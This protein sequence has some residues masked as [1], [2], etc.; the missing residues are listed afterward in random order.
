[1]QDRHRETPTERWEG[2]RAAPR[3][4]RVAVEE[5]L[6]IRLGGEGVVV[7]MRT[8]G[9]DFELAAGFLF[10]EGI[11]TEASQIGAIAYC[12][13]E[14]DPELRNIVEVHAPDGVEL[15]AAGYQ[16]QFFSGTSCGLCGKSSIDAVRLQVDPVPDDGARFSP[17]T[18]LALPD[19][20][21]AGQAVFDETG[22]LHAAGLFDAGGEL[23]CLREDVGR[24]NAVDKVI[25]WALL[26]GRLPLA[27]HALM[28]S[29]R[30]SFEIIQK[31]AVARLPLV[32]AV[33]APSSLAVDLARECRMTL[34]GFLRGDTFNVYAGG[35]RLGSRT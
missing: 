3:D 16:R 1:M 27:G 8:P 17:E 13:D 19:R 26:R 12:E 14:S 9:A 21:R 32:A 18:L 4:D 10:T 5:P 31:A 28:V 22:G 25:G 7:V 15:S 35:E 34:V 29:G 23:V 33:S 20:L 6:E 24:H 11:V 2:G 30:S